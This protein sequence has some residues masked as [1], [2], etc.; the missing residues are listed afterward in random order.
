MLHILLHIFFAIEKCNK[1]CNKRKRVKTA[2]TDSDVTLFGSQNVYNVGFQHFKL[3]IYNVTHFYSFKLYQHSEEFCIFAQPF[4]PTMIQSE[5]PYVYLTLDRRLHDVIRHESKS[6]CD[7]LLLDSDSM[8]GR[9]IINRVEMSLFPPKPFSKE[10]CLK[11]YLPI[12]DS[13]KYVYSKYYL[14][15]SPFHREQ[16]QDEIKLFL[17]LRAWQWD[18]EAR[19]M[20]YREKEIVE[21]FCAAYGMRQSEDRH[22]LVKKIMYRQRK[23]IREE[24]ARSVSPMH[25]KNSPRR[26]R[27]EKRQPPELTLFREE[28]C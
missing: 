22:E 3:K 24:I 9:F 28:K 4:A 20:G 17:K 14:T 18:V 25:M 21:S 1:K 13:T 23:N 2:V 19:A 11:L 10:D 8:L 12:S 26:M 15:L 16:I 5:R 7:G 6:M 27:S